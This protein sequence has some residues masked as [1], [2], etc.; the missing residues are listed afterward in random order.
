MKKQNPKYLWKHLHDLTDKTKKHQNP[1][2]TDANEEPVLDPGQ[3]ADSFNDF[4]FVS[5]F[6]KYRNASGESVYSNEKLN[7]YI[8]NKLHLKLPSK[9]LPCQLPLYRN[10]CQHLR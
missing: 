1:V 5:I 9:Y 7:T 10:N 2:I 6:E 8:K 3:M 4:F